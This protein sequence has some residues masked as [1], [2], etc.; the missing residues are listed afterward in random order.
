VTAAVCADLDA[1]RVAVGELRLPVRLTLDHS[2]VVVHMARD[3]N[4]PAEVRVLQVVEGFTGD[5]RR[6]V[7]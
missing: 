2:T 7:T 3:L 4:T 1:L 5:F 6:Q